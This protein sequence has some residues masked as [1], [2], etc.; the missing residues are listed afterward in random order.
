MKK[1]RAKY[2]GTATKRL[3]DF[4]RGRTGIARD[5][6][7][8]AFPSVDMSALALLVEL[9]YVA[10]TP[11]GN[12]NGGAVLAAYREAKREEWDARRAAKRREKLAKL[13]ARIAALREQEAAQ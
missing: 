3:A 12:P 8:A 5:M 4:V 2:D 7:V 6:V 11:R 10:R 9:G 13:E 1:T